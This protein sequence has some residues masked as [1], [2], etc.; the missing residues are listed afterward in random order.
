M[1]FLFFLLLIFLL[2]VELFAVDEQLK[3]TF[4]VQ[5]SWTFEIW[6]G[7]PMVALNC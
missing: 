4:Q 6:I 5:V 1:L 7:F 2:L 3:A